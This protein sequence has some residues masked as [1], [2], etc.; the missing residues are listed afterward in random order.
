MLAAIEDPNGDGNTA[1]SIADNTLILFTSDNGGTH[2][3]NLPLR[4]VKGM[5]TEGG[6]RVPLIAYW[7]GVVPANTTTEHTVHAVDYYPT[8]LELA[9]NDW[10]PPVAEHPLDGESFAAILR[11]PQKK[12]KR[13][14]IFYLFPGY[15]DSRAQPTVVAMDIIQDKR[16][17]L[18]YFYEADAWELYCISD[19][20]GEANNII[21]SHPE[22]ASVLSKKMNTWLTQKHA[23]WKP[24]FPLSKKSGKSVG[25]PPVL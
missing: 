14:A 18:L 3:D 6:I 25:P 10:T 2:F 1:D 8:C 17:K 24:K 12:Q 11:K 23:T 19:D 21:K 16:Y 4:G 15:M 9:G 13:G 20:Q 5:F 22:I 7:P